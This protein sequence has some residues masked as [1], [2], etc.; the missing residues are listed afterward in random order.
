MKRT[1]RCMAVALFGSMLVA[2][3][4]DARGMSALGGRPGVASNEHCFTINSSGVIANN[5]GQAC[6]LVSWMVSLDTDSNNTKT[7]NVGFWDF[8]QNTS[9]SGCFS[10]KSHHDGFGTQFSTFQRATISNGF[11][12]LAVTGSVIGSQDMLVLQC[13]LN[14]GDNLTQIDWNN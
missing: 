6:G 9:S 11:N 5:I 4:A 1:L 8:S 3:T 14:Q 13:N 12:N 7:I 2:G 10:I